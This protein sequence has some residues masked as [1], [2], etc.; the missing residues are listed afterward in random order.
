MQTKRIW[1]S[2]GSGVNILNCL[3]L[4]FLASHSDPS[5]EDEVNLGLVIVLV[6]FSVVI[7]TTVLSLVFVMW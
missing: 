2:H 7:L 5:V 1:S 6:L 4:L 3:A